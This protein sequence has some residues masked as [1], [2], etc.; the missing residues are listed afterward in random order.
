MLS[1]GL[2]I[3]GCGAGPGEPESKMTSYTSKESE[4]AE[5]FTVPQEQMVHLQI[6]AVEKTRLERVLRLP[7]SVAYN[8]FKTTPVFPAIGGPVHE[9]LVAP[10]ET[11][12]AGAPLLTV[13]SPDYAMA[14]ATYI[15]AKDTM[16]LANKNFH[17]A[18]D[19]YAHGL[20]L[21]PG[22]TSGVGDQGSR[23]DREKRR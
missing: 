10:G 9:I 3:A 11:V 22:C 5:L 12:Q 4:I 1:L 8:Q 21:Q 14:R 7:G 15:K 6:L 2:V 23:C 16:Q 20:G 19:L 17:R 18:E 13:N